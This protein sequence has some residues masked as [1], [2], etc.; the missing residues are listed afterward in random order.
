MNV[1]VLGLTGGYCAGKNLAADILES[2]GYGMIDV[3]RLGH[4]ALRLEAEALVKA[5]GIGILRPD[6]SVDRRALGSIVFPDPEKLKLHESIV[7]PTMLR[8]LDAALSGYASGGSG[9]VCINAALLYRFPQASR[10]DL[11][12]EITAPLEARI[13]RGMARDGLSREDILERIGRQSP[14]WRLRS[15]A[16]VP[17]AIVVNDSDTP[18]LAARLAKVLE[19]AGF[20]RL[21]ITPAPT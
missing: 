16:G 2:S 12:V 15:Q 4:E 18:A 8:L 7:H 10:C 20:P 6:G 3:D 13:A 17:V 14:L 11:I 5:F 1:S 19:A 9:A 21:S